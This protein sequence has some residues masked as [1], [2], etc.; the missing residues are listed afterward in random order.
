MI[1]ELERY[2]IYM[3]TILIVFEYFDYHIFISNLYSPILQVHKAYVSKY[4][5]I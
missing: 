5:T 2:I 3:Y 1:G 4:K